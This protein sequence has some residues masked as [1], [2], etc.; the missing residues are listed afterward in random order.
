VD[1]ITPLQCFIAGLGMS[2]IGIGAIWMLIWHQIVKQRRLRF[3]AIAPAPFDVG[4]EKGPQGRSEDEHLVL[5]RR[6]VELMERI[7]ENQEVMIGLLRQSLEEK[8]LS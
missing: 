5:R 7:V 2:L 8:V 3:G 4:P 1:H 6:E